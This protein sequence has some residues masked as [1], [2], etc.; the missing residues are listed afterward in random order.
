MFGDAKCHAFGLHN[1]QIRGDG[2][3]NSAGWYNHNGER[4]GN[5]DLSLQDMVAIAKDLDPTEVFI[6]IAEIDASWDFPTHLDHSA[7][8]KDYVF[9]KAVWIIG[10]D[11]THGAAIL[12]VRNDIQKPEKAE[13]NGIQYFRYPRDDFYKSVGY[14]PKK[15]SSPEKPKD[16]KVDLDKMKEAADK[17][18]TAV[19][20]I[21]T[22]SGQ[23]PLPL[24]PSG[25]FIGVLPNGKV[26]AIP[27]PVSPGKSVPLSPASSPT[28][29][30]VKVK[31]ISKP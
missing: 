4:L 15:I 7:P 12:R 29:K 20:K 1:N 23:Q 26:G 21:K 25:S 14:T 2:I 16:K 5:G 30:V 19:K 11:K 6:A 9:Q 17:L 8:G 13:Q 3:I 10:N 24:P 27:I 31:R 22:A 18:K 28:K